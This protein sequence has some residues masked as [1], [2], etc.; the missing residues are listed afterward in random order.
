MFNSYVK[1]PEGIPQHPM[2]D[3][4]IPASSVFS[5]CFSIFTPTQTPIFFQILPLKSQHF[6]PQ[7]RRDLRLGVQHLFR[8]VVHI[9]TWRWTDKWPGI[10]QL[11]TRGVPPGHPWFGLPISPAPLHGSCP[12][13][14]WWANETPANPTRCLARGRSLGLGI[15]P[16]GHRFLGFRNDGFMTILEDIYRWI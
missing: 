6:G 13:P 9:Q 4:H 14:W 5:C 15:Q 2:V 10:G 7:I 1:L 16:W 8:E 12:S 3:H 11:I